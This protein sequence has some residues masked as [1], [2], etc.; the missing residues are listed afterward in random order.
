M[1][2]LDAVT[3]YPYMCV[4]HRGIWVYH[5]CS[6]L[7]FNKAVFYWCMCKETIV[8]GLLPCLSKI[9]ILH[10]NRRRVSYL[11]L[12]RRRS[13][14]CQD[15][16]AVLKSL[17]SCNASADSSP[18]PLFEASQRL[19]DPKPLPGQNQLPSA[20]HTPLHRVSAAPRSKTAFSKSSRPLKRSLP[21]R[22]AP[23]FLSRLSFPGSPIGRSLHTR[24][25]FSFD[26]T[27]R[28]LQNQA[29]PRTWVSI[30]WTPL[31]SSW[32][33]RRNSPSRCLMRMPS[34]FPPLMR[35]S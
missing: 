21:R 15:P 19:P 35:Y 7:W 10:S 20:D 18:L 5:K 33:L 11:V 23:S 34:A 28:L 2:P 4:C 14:F 13:L 1:I 8:A 16:T 26:A 22:S 30:H 31:R 24:T 12:S 9:T 6:V 17:P 25:S 3:V 32:P 29:S 27:Y